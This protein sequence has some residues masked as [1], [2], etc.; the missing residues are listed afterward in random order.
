MLNY[1]IFKGKIKILAYLKLLP[2]MKRPGIDYFCSSYEEI[3]HPFTSYPDLY[4]VQ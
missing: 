1:N 3:H 2:L 4:Q